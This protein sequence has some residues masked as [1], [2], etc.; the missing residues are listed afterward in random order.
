MMSSM[1]RKA[2]L[3]LSSE[4]DNPNTTV[5]DLEV[6][7]V[8]TE[9]D[10]VARRGL[11][12]ALA[13]IA[14]GDADTLLLARLGSASGSLGELVRLLD[15]LAEADATLVAADVELDTAQDVGRNAAVLLRE[16]DGW[17]REHRAERR[18]RGRPGLAAGSP[19]LAER[20]A[21]LRAS[22]LSLQSIADALNERGI[23]TPR[24]GTQWRPSSV[25]AALGYR[26]PRPPMPGAP[27]PRPPGR[28]H[29]PHEHPPHEHPPHAQP[30]HEH[31]P[32]DPRRQPPPPRP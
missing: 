18:P 19:E 2:V 8:I 7:E 21:E 11:S 15:W 22:G 23:P 6:V 3:Y 1:S 4:D 30:P 25:Q 29:P 24:G 32:H 28:P 26:R 5:E 31:P 9:T 20:I 10:A 13:R 16:I 27:P 17:G 12:T 14:A